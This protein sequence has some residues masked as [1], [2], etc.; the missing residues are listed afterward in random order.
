MGQWKHR[1]TNIDS[2]SRNAHCDE[3]GSNTAVVSKGRGWRCGIARKLHRGSPDAARKYSREYYHH[4]KPKRT[5]SV[6]DVCKKEKPLCWDHDHKTG[7]HRGWLCH[8]CNVGIGFLLDD[9]EILEAAIEYLRKTKP[10]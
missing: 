6:C 2:V 1:L 4:N 10:P 9:V 7:L 8:G 5:V 3:C